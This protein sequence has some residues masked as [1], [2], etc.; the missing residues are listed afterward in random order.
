[1]TGEREREQHRGGATAHGED[2][3]HISCEK[4][5]AH[6]RPAAPAKVEVPPLHHGIG[7]DEP[8][9]RREQ[10]SIVTDAPKPGPPE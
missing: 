9:L 2:V 5:E 1:M 6:I 3:A 7:H 4:F 8:V 10:R